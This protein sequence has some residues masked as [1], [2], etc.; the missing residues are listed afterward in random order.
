MNAELGVLRGLQQSASSS[1]RFTIVALDHRQNLRH[2]LR[3][4]DPASVP[5]AD[6][7]HFKRQAV[8]ALAPLATAVLLDPEVGAAQ[9]IADGSLPGDVGLV[10][11]LEATGYEGPS[12]ARRSR[13]VEGWSAAQARRLG[14]SAAKL[15]VYYHPA[16]ASAERQEAVVSASVAECQAAGLPLFVEPLAYSIE[17]DRQLAGD[18]RRRVITETARRMAALGANVLKLQFPYGLEE[19]DRDRWRAACEDLTGV[20]P[21]WVLLSGD[22]SPD[23]FVELAEIACRAGASGIACGRGIW[24]EAPALGV[25]ERTHFFKTVAAPRLRRL[26]EIVEELARPWTDVIDSPRGD[27]EGW[28]RSNGSG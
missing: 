1:G 20:G 8:R 9:C 23:E 27:L 11:A 19:T 10:V 7:I 18:E 13:L 28:F 24:A 17:A 22:S 14:A 12:T 5:V 6:M 25:G 4:E 2:M 26:A 3:P 15:L 16:A 21:P